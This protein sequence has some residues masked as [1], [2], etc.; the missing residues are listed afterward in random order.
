[1][2]VK[3][4]R[5]GEAPEV[6]KTIKAYDVNGETQ[7]LEITN[8]ESSNEANEEIKKYEEEMQHRMYIDNLKYND[9]EKYKKI[10]KQE[11]KTKFMSILFLTWFATSIILLIVFSAMKKTALV[12][13]V[14]GHYFAIFGLI[15]FI[16]SKNNKKSDRIDYLV[17]ILFMIFGFTFMIG[18]IL[19]QFGIIFN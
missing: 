17:P 12:I 2:S 3:V 18:G 15:F 19:Y 4:Y 1:M 7:T 14:F 9:P 6:H 16:G 5:K 13:S 10:I 11:R 8:E